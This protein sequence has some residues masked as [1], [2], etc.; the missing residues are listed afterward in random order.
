M[1]LDLGSSKEMEALYINNQEI[2]FHFW[3]GPIPSLEDLV[4]Q[5]VSPTETFQ[6]EFRRKQSG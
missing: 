2:S 3:D 1:E 4:N 5:A 6:R